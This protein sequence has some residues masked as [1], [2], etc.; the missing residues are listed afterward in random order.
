MPGWSVSD[1]AGLPVPAVQL[2]AGL[3][4]TDLG[5]RPELVAGVHAVALEAFDDIPGGDTPM[6]AGDL[7]EFR[8]R[9]VDRPGDPTPERSWSRSTEATDEVV[10]YA[11]LML[12]PG[13]TTVRLA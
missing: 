6:A 13:S 9:D 11:S 12:V 8:A 3:G 1:L 2:P 10:G 7:A 5:Q 4:L